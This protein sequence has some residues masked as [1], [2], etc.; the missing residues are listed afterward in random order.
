MPVVAAD[1]TEIRRVVTRHGIGRL[2]RPGDA[3]SLAAA[4]REA[5]EGYADHVQAVAA[6]RPALSWEAD[7][8]VLLEA[9]RELG[10]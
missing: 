1:L 3:A 9:Y 7:A 4:V 5:V 6:A 2:Y 8:R 10:P